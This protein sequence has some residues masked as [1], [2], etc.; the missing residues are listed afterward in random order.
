MAVL[1]SG[2]TPGAVVGRV[3]RAL[4]GA[5]AKGPDSA[6]RAAALLQAAQMALALGFEDSARTLYDAREKM[7]VK[8]PLRSMSC[9]F[10]P[11]L[12]MCGKVKAT[13]WDM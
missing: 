10:T 11:T 3:D 2:A 4:K 13:I 7:L 5:D 1:E 6:A 9:T 12:P 8:A